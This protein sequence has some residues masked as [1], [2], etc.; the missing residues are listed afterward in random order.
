MAGAFTNSPRSTPVYNPQQAAQL[1][2]GNF[3]QFNQGISPG[4]YGG[5]MGAG[6]YGGGMG[7][8]GNIYPLGGGMAHTTIYAVVESG[9]PIIMNPKTGEPYPPG[10]IPTIQDPS[11]WEQWQPGQS[12]TETMGLAKAEMSEGMRKAQ[13]TLLRPGEEAAAETAQTFMQD[14]SKAANKWSGQAAES[15]YGKDNKTL[16]N[17][18]EQAGK[19]G[20]NAI[21]QAP[22]IAQ[23][24]LKSGTQ[25]AKQAAQQATQK[26][27]ETTKKLTGAQP[28]QAPKGMTSVQT[29][30]APERPAAR[31]SQGSAT[32][33]TGAFTGSSSATF[34]RN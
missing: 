11:T 21:N 14:L 15:L 19:E 31:F 4:G 23:G 16:K 29:S 6:G 8:G 13:E 18:Q 9:Q 3:E 27:T 33:G 22:G 2:N 34:R 10:Y 12:W 28:A 24:A 1:G 32:Q 30:V 7:A 25:I 17:L 20:R 5:G 26:I